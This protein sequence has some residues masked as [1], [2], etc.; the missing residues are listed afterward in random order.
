MR[1]IKTRTTIDASPDEV[2]KVL[3]DLELYKDW[4]PFITEATGDAVEGERLKLKMSPPD[5]RSMSFR[6]TVLKADPGREFRWLGHLGV[7][8]IFDGEHYFQLRELDNGGTELLQGEKFTGIA[9]GLLGGALKNTER[10]FEL[11]N[12]AL[13][14]QCEKTK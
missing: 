8:G 11:L 5:G 14:K 6:P 4:N 13:R 7:R 3:T 1:E 12:E 10:G 2:W 9:V